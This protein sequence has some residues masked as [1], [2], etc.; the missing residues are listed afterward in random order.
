MSKLRIVPTQELKIVPVSEKPD[1]SDQG[2][3]AFLTAAAERGMENLGSIP[4]N[5]AEGLADFVMGVPKPIQDMADRAGVAPPMDHVSSFF[6]GF[7]PS[8]ENMVAGIES[9]I[10]G[11]P[12]TQEDVAEFNSLVGEQNPAADSLGDLTGD[13]LT[14][15]G[16]RKPVKNAV[17][18]QTGKT[19]G[20]ILDEFVDEGLN[21]LSNKAGRAAGTTGFRREMQEILDGDNF[22]LLARG[23]GRSLETGLEAAVLS[24]FQD[25]DPYEIAGFA[26]GAQMVSSAALTAGSAS[27]DIASA[28]VKFA[29][30][31]DVGRITKYGTALAIQ[32]AVLAGW[33]NL[34]SDNPDQATEAAFDK[35]SFGIMGAMVLGLPGKRPKDDGILRSFPAAADLVLSTPRTAMNN[36]IISVAGDPKVEPVIELMTTDPERLGR[37]EHRR[38]NLAIE[39]GWFD[40]WVSEVHEKFNLED[41]EN[42]MSA[43]AAAVPIRRI[44]APAFKK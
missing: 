17:E 35:L 26:M 21:R 27:V 13:V 37:T 41:T 39:E 43:E 5:T 33:L 6:D 30:G 3:N 23:A 28:P 15:L 24:S 42:G 10:P 12:G 44:K 29:F 25:Q 20:G 7:R 36:A 32:G 18:R 8:G 1:V 14:L 11:V 34:F 31:K 16:L 4:A 40:R 9:A 38:M 2:I 19:S 22:R